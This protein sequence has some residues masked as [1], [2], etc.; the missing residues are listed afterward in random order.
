MDTLKTI[1]VAN[2]RD[3]NAL[4]DYLPANYWIDY[5]RD[6]ERGPVAIV[7]GRD[8]AGWTA[9]GY[10]IPRLRSGLIAARLVTHP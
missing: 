10:V 7:R 4:A 6:T 2:Y 3:I 9:D 8:S 5:V 1:E